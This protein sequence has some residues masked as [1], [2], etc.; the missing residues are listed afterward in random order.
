MFVPN[1]RWIDPIRHTRTHSL[2]LLHKFHNA[3]AYLSAAQRP[4]MWQHKCRRLYKL[5]LSRASVRGVQVLHIF[6]L[7]KFQQHI[8][9]DK[10]SSGCR[11]SH[12]RWTWTRYFLIKWKMAFLVTELADLMKLTGKR[13]VCH[14]VRLIARKHHSRVNDLFLVCRAFDY[15]FP[16]YEMI[17]CETLLRRS[18]VAWLYTLRGCFACLM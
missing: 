6:E 17:V 2:T 1:E 12:L 8:F 10:L 14:A 18:Q 13:V 16:E 3:N 15:T 9:N 4:F 11:F 7:Y 5:R